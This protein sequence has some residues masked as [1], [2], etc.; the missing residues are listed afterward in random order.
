MDA[1]EQ[2]YAPASGAAAEVETLLRRVAD[3]V[4][5]ARQMPLSTSVMI[6]RDEVLELVE[7]AV[8]RLPEELRAARWLLR[9]RQEFLTKVQR[10]GDDILEAARVRAER[11]VQRTEVVREAQAVARRTVEEAEVQ[12]RRLRH[13]A[14]DFCDQKLA[15]F[16]IV[17]DRTVKTVQA[18]RARLQVA[19]PEEDV[20]QDEEGFLGEDGEGVEGFYD[21]DSG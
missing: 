3:L 9:E 17:L 21:Q 1:A 14:E 2:E 16:E 20:D 8:N 19:L 13:Q 6:N 7:E 18:G 4:G 12:A 15:Q 10:E 11:M 5:N